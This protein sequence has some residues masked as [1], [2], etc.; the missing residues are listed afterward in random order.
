MAK[1]VRW[2]S[3]CSSGTDFW[4]RA[5]ERADFPEDGWP[6]RIICFDGIDRDEETESRMEDHKSCGGASGVDERDIS[7]AER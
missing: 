1:S 2:S 4:R 6:R 7:I 3:F 5:E